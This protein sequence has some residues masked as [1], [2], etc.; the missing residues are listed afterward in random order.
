MGSQNSVNV[1]SYIV[2]FPDD[3]HIV[4]EGPKNASLPILLSYYQILN[5]S[6]SKT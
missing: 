4:W 5:E 2:S 3:Q 1:I 6:I